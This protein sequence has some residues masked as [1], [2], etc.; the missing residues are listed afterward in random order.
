MRENEENSSYA[1]TTDRGIHHG[2]TVALAG[3]S[4]F[5][6][7]FLPW[8]WQLKGIRGKCKYTNLGSNMGKNG[9]KTCKTHKRT[10]PK[11]KIE[12]RV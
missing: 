5:C 8:A 4:F 3:S 11:H 2:Q 9:P 6:S 1:F 10:I 12:K 7:Y